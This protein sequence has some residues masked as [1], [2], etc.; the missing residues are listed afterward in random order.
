MRERQGIQFNC[1]SP[2][3]M[4]A[5]IVIEVSLALY[6]LWRYK[7]SPTIRLVI[8]T[9]LALATFQLAEYFVCTNSIGHPIGW[10]RFGFAA[11]TLLPPLGLHLMHRL[12]DKP[13]RRL[14]ST[15]YFTTACFVLFFLLFP[16]VFDSYQCT[17]NYVIFRLRAHAGG[18]YWLYYFG[19]IITSVVLGVRWGNQ[20]S[21]L[22]KKAHRQLQ[23]VQALIIGW[24]IFIVPTAIANV[25]NPASRQGIPSIMCGFAVLLALILGLYIVPRISELKK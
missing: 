3:V 15:A 1:F 20:L 21:K 14:V 10:S 4:I 24:F 12:A 7:M 25:V 9:L 11:I 6:T 18:L 19:W 23:A 13:V 5:T 2:P 22:G 16:N 17:G 8:I